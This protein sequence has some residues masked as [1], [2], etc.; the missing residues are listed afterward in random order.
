MSTFTTYSSKT[1]GGIVIEEAA[2]NGYLYRGI[3]RTDGKAVIYAKPASSD[4]F[5]LVTH[6]KAAKRWF[7]RMAAEAKASFG[8]QNDDQ[9]DQDERRYAEA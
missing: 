3:L 9:A 5:S 7:D 1:L 8:Y 6:S 4:K 2:A